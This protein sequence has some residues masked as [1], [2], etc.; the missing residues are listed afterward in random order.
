MAKDAVTNTDSERAV[1]DAVVEL[2]LMPER[3]LSALKSRTAGTQR[4]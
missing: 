1:Y 4:A 2:S 3:V